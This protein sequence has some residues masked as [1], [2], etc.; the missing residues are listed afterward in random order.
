MRMNRRAFLSSLAGAAA[1]GRAAPVSWK[2]G[3]AAVDITPRSSIW[4]AGFAARKCPSE[5]VALPLHAKAL[6]LDDG[7]RRAVLVTVDLLG[8]TAPMAERITSTIRR[9][10]RLPREALLLNA[11]HTHCGPVT[12]DMLSVAYDLTVEQRGVIRAYTRELEANVI[13]VIGSALTRLEPVRLG[14]GEGS[15]PFAANRRVQF[16]PDGPVDRAVPVLRVA[17]TNGRPLAIVFGYACHNT[18]LQGDFCRFHGDYAGVAQAALEERHN[19]TMA[20]FVAGC[21]ADQNPKPRGT[22]E[23]VQQHGRTLADAVDRTLETTTVA[24][25]L[26]TAYDTVDLAFAP[27]PGRDEWKAKLGDE[28]VYVRRHARLMLDAIDRDGRLASVQPDPIQVWR[29]GHAGPPEGGHHDGFTLITMG[30]EVV[31]DYSLKLKK[32]YAGQR[33]W[34]AAYS[35]DVFGYVPSLRV[36]EEGGYEGGGAMMYYGKPGPF[37]RDVEDRIHEKIRTLMGRAGWKTN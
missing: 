4:M 25:P 3:V 8:V 13:G 19:G 6:A 32:D 37:A 33:I 14:F 10:H 7:R 26:R 35:N 23:L 5:G 24:G 29:F 12:D 28:N 21:G 17:R 11:S 34:A 16:T 30:G 36:L 27:A 31:V 22:V 9:R 1:F 18:T 2:A 15:A 20:L